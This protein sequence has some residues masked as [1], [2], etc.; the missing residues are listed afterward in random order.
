MDNNPS[1]IV[2]NLCIYRLLDHAVIKLVPGDVVVSEPVIWTGCFEV[3]FRFYR[4]ARITPVAPTVKYV[5]RVFTAIRSP[6]AANRAPAR[7]SPRTT[8]SLAKSTLMGN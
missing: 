8:L 5:P 3:Y 2:E 1:F 7:R 6:V 4:T